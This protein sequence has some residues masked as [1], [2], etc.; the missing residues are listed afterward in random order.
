[1]AVNPLK[2]KPQLVKDFWPRFKRG[3]VVII[4]ALQ[5]LILI[6]L[7][8]LLTTSGF[9]NDNPL[10]FAATLVAQSILGIVAS[11]VIIICRCRVHSGKAC[12]GNTLL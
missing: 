7:A 6:A 2:S 11:V 10:G 8:A 12:S 4:I 1:M 3:T 5:L 9:F